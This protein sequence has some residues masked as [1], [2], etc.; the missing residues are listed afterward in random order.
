MDTF[1]VWLQAL[2][3]SSQ[4]FQVVWLGIHFDAVLIFCLIAGGVFLGVGLAIGA[5]LLAIMRSMGDKPNEW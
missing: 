2:G 1:L 4:A 5:A 3:A